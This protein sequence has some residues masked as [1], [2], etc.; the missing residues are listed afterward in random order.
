MPG[1]LPGMIIAIGSPILYDTMRVSALDNSRHLQGGACTYLVL[2]L[3]RRFQLCIVPIGIG[4]LH[5]AEGA[6]KEVRPW[7]FA[8]N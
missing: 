4:S 8:A 3:R 6:E 1:V 2:S 5:Y 7:M